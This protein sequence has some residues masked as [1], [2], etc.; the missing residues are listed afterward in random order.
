MQT[1][2]VAYAEEWKFDHG[3]A[4]PPFPD[5]GLRPA[6]RTGQH[7][8]ARARRSRPLKRAWA[9]GEALRCGGRRAGSGWRW[10]HRRHLAALAG[11]R[12]TP[13]D[14]RRMGTASSPPGTLGGQRSRDALTSYSGCRGSTAT[15]G[16][17]SF[18]IRTFVAAPPPPGAKGRIEVLA[19]RCRSLP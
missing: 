19:N 16:R 8:S 3:I 18:E 14:Q 13:V 1:V 7:Q 11:K 2:D 10:R 12:L 4:V 6:D 17:G 15:A 5:A 9:F